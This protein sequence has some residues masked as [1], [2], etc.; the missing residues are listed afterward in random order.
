MNTSLSFEQLAQS[1]LGR[2]PW[3]VK[4]SRQRAFRRA[5]SQAYATFSQ[6]YPDWADY[7]FDEHFLTHQA[8]P[9]LARH[10]Q[11]YP[12]PQPAELAQ[13]WAGQLF[14]EEESLK[15]KHI[16]ALMPA[17]ASFLRL[18]ESEQR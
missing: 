8:A 16:A 14:W 9:L 4:Q 2:Q 15:Q 3:L 11:G 7:L 1:W 17:A 6:N 18:L 5:I 12:P 13:V 10:L